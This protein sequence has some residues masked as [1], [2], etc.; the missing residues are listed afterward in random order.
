M[1]FLK[2]VSRQ[3]ENGDI[4]TPQTAELL[5]IGGGWKAIGYSLVATSPELVADNM[6]GKNRIVLAS[7]GPGA[8]AEF[9]AWFHAGNEQG[10]VPVWRYYISHGRCIMGDA[11]FKN[12][13]VYRHDTK[14][15]SVLVEFVPFDCEGKVDMKLF[16]E[17][18]SEEMGVKSAAEEFLFLSKVIGHGAKVLWTC[19]GDKNA[20]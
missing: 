16:A 17:V 3:N 6:W 13:I 5:T 19:S 1:D 18:L 10:F 14:E 2:R 8:I 7:Q 12:T 4:S 20:A 9:D 11:E 15:G